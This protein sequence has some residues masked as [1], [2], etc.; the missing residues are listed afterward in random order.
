MALS[1]TVVSQG[2]SLFSKTRMCHFFSV[3]ACTRGSDCSFAHDETEL[4]GRPNLSK[5][6]LC[7]MYTSTGECS[8]AYCRFAHGRDELL[9]LPVARGRKG[10][11][12]QIPSKFSEPSRGG[13]ATHV[14]AHDIVQDD[15]GW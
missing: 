10:K 1:K 5:T 7:R 6:K 12:Q 11:K 8:D 2:D 4:V 3:G 15:V 14:G 13:I 9:K